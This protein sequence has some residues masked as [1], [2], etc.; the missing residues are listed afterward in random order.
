MHCFLFY[1]YR[2]LLVTFECMLICHNDIMFYPHV[3]IG[4]MWIYRL[5][6]VFVFLYSYGFL[7]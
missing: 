2:L 7:H 6:F 5:L 4:K 1:P 3:L